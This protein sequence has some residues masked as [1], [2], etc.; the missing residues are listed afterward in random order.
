[1]SR[2]STECAG[3]DSLHDEDN[4]S[5][6]SHKPNVALSNRIT[7]LSDPILELVLQTLCDLHGI[8][9]V[10]RL[11]VTSKEVPQASR[12]A[13]PPSYHWSTDCSLQ[14]GAGIMDA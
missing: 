14:L 4:C 13:H 5:G 11:A 7:Q 8:E 2:A 12:I 1:M 9:P 3:E 10:M 6:G